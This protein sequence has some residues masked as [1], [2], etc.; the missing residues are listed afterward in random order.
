MLRSIRLLLCVIVR[1]FRSQRSLLLENLALRQQ[2][3][4]LKRKHPKPRLSHFDRLFWVMVRRMWSKWKDALVI[5]TPETVVGWHR[6]G[7]GL[8]WRWRSQ[9]QRAL[10]R[11]PV[12]KELR[13]L[14]F[15][16]GS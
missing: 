8:Y 1:L 13:D 11:R 6:A 15:R 14:I 16:N 9:H 3:V 12:P 7:F 2:L 4:T 5:V 10:R